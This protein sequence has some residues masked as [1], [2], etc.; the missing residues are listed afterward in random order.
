[1]R[2][3]RIYY[4]NGFWGDE[5][6]FSKIDAISKGE[7]LAKENDTTISKVRMLKE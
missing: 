7:I 1:M 4:A 3:F 2:L 6:A 5:I